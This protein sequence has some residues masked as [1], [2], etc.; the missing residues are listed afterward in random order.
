LKT[1]IT[2]AGGFFS[3]LCIA[4]GANQTIGLLQLDEKS[5]NVLL[6]AFGIVQCFLTILGRMSLLFLVNSIYA[7]IP[8]FTTLILIIISVYSLA[9]GRVTGSSKQKT[10]WLLGALAVL[11]VADYYIR[12]NGEAQTVIPGLVQSLDV[13]HV[14]LSTGFLLLIKVIDLNSDPRD[15]FKQKKD[16]KSEVKRLV[17]KI[18]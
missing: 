16:F 7:A 17:N 4:L 15:L 11:G 10:Y 6:I 9:T 8:L 1:E 5:S 18:K 13:Y 12:A 3:I 2:N 14:I